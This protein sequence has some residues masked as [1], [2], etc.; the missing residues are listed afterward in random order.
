MAFWIVTSSMSPRKT[1]KVKYPG[2]PVEH[3]LQFRSEADRFKYRG[4]AK[5]PMETF[6]EMYFD[7]AVDFKGDALEMLEYRHDWASFRFTWGLFRFFLTG[8]LPELLM[9][10][11]SQGERDAWLGDVY[12]VAADMCQLPQTKSKSVSITIVETTFTAGSL[13][14]G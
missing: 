9:H 5:I 13:V 7:G 2:R 10:T 1:E 4:K 6:H 11:R 8:M 14:H 3:Y 12:V